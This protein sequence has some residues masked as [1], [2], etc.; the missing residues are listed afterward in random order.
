[1]S[2]WDIDP[3]PGS[4]DNDYNGSTGLE[5]EIPRD[6]VQT[7]RPDAST[8]SQDQRFTAGALS[9]PQRRFIARFAEQY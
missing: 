4:G 9:E 3:D 2:D 6:P 5:D 8:Q 1:M 7:R